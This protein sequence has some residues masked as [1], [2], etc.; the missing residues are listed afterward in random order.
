MTATISQPQTPDLSTQALNQRAMLVALNIKAWSPRKTDETVTLEVA[1]RKA[2]QVAAKAAGRYTKNLIP[3]SAKL[4]KVRL[5]ISSARGEFYAKTLPWA[6]DGSRIISPELW[7]GLASKV[8]Q[9]E[10]EFKAAVEEFLLEY[11]SLVQQAKVDLG[12]LYLEGEYPTVE[13]LRARFA[14][15]LSVYPLPSAQDFRVDLGAEVTNVLKTKIEADVRQ[16]MVE[17]QQESWKKL[18]ERVEHMIDRLSNPDAV[19]RDSLVEGLQEVTDTAKKL[20]VAGD[21][22]LEATVSAIENKLL[23]FDPETLRKDKTTRE[24]VVRDARAIFE[25]MKGY[26]GG[27]V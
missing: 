19:F 20:N 27:A 4:E 8:S 17:A 24:T 12:D 25:Q 3:K 1:Q 11:P 21:L 26:M 22:G 7:F 16:Q 5:V 18:A 13:Q 9:L 15:S 10:T 14:W 6:Q 23:A 2:V